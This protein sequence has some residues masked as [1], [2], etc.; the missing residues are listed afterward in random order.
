[1]TS[2]DLEPRT[3]PALA[4][5]PLRGR[6]VGVAAVVLLLVLWLH[7]LPALV[8]AL[9]GFVLYRVVGGD[10]P[11]ASWRDHARTAVLTGLLLLLA[12]FTFFQVFE[13]LLNASHGG[14]PRLLQL[15]ADTLDQIRATAPAWIVG[16]LP[17]SAV[18]LQGSV[19]GWLR[20]HAGQVQQW[21]R[22]AF[23]V[24]L[25]LVVG[26]AIGLLAAGRMRTLPGAR[27]PRVAQER[28]VQVTLAFADIMAAQLRISLVN[29]ALTALYLL[30]GLKLFGYHVPLSLTLVAVTFVASFLPIVGNL[31][32]NTAIIVASLTISAWLGVTSLVFLVVVHK[33]EYFLN[34]HFVGSRIRMPPYALLMSMLVLEAAFGA[35]GL[36]AAPIYCAWFIREA[37]DAGWLCSLGKVA[38]NFSKWPDQ[39]EDDRRSR[40]L[41]ARGTALRLPARGPRGKIVRRRAPAGGRRLR[42]CPCRATPRSWAA[43]ARAAGSCRIPICRRTGP[44]RRSAPRRPRPTGPGACA[45]RPGPW[46]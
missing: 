44:T 37:R 41:L 12:G 13:L 28:W 40:I 18:S 19:S 16:W 45:A 3:D 8:G 27:L 32:S 38:N 11:A 20:S 25:H 26:L 34:A 9:V 39:C 17:D 22:D 29:S 36:V 7:L 5:E 23:R 6:A 35:P 31:L 33:L 15:M 2:R 42:A 1:M 24:V 4:A 14:L 10:K 21:G 30:V 43:I 46:R